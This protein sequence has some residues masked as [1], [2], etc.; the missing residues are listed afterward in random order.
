MTSR[1]I[2]SLIFLSLSSR[3]ANKDARVRREA[4]EY[5][6]SGQRLLAQRNDHGAID[7]YQKVLSLPKNFW[8]TKSF[9]NLGVI[10]VH[11]RNPQKDLEKSLDFF[12]NLIKNY[13]KSPFVEQAKMWVGILEEN[14]E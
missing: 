10:Y 13:P 7:E 8:K 12:K 4:Q 2:T 5:L 6:L 3:A 9:F 1:C 11:L 14:E